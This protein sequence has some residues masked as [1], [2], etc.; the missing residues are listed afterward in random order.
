MDEI[1]KDVV[2]WEG[3]YKVSNIGNIKSENRSA[4]TKKGV[5]R[6]KERI[7]AFRLGNNGYFAC[8][9]SFNGIA[10]KNNVHRLVAEAFIPNPENK[11]EVNH[12]DGNKQNNNVSNL[13]WATRSENG[14]H[15]WK[16]GL[17][18]SANLG[19]IGIKS[20]LSKRISQYTLDMCFIKTYDAVSDVEREKGI[21]HGNISMCANGIRNHAGGFIWRY[22]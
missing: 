2:G 17:N 5:Y 12:I 10:K 18:H 9:L 7:L 3:F 4:P 8:A 16:N 21:S 20:R 11:P 14:L 19:M 13:E 6:V 22:E 15:A 1:W